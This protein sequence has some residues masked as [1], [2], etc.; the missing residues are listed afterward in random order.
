MDEADQAVR[1][2]RHEGLDRLSGRDV[3]LL[4]GHFDTTLGRQ[5]LDVVPQ[6]LL[7]RLDLAGPRQELDF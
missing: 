6:R 4:L 7:R 5:P 3:A 2:F 1:M